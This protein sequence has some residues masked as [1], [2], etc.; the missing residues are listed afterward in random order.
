VINIDELVDQ[1]A[2]GIKKHPSAIKDFLQYAKNTFAVT[3]QYVFLIGKGITYDQYITNQNSQYADKLNLVPTFGSPASDVLLSSPYGS[4]VPSIPIGRLSAVSGDEVG[5]YLQKMKEYELAENSTN[6]TLADKLWMKNVVHIAGGREV[7]EN[8][9]FSFYLNQYQ[10]IIEDTLYGA[11]VETF[12]KSSN[13][14]VQLISGQRI[15]DL[16]NEGISLLTYFGHS[17]ANVLEFNLSDPSVYNN[18]G[19]YP[20]F[21]VSGC[22]VGNNYIYDTLRIIQNNLTI[23]EN[24]VLSKEKGSIGFLADTHLGIPPFLNDYDTQIL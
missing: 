5:N 15:N 13:S 17:S 20:F 14:A 19:R 22:S 16:F 6:Q 23:S 12:S 7:S 21:L 10:G 3:P 9:L 4:I 2:Y 18:H 8:D 24:F 11:H 1:F